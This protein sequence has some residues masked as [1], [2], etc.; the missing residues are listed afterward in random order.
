MDIKPKIGPKHFPSLFDYD[1]DSNNRVAH[2]YLK[3]ISKENLRRFDPWGLAYVEFIQAQGQEVKKIVYGLKNPHSNLKHFEAFKRRTSFL[4]INNS[5][6]SFEIKMEN[7][8]YKLYQLEGLKRRPANEIIRDSINIRS[9]DNVSGRLEKDFQVFLFGSQQISNAKI[10]ERLGLLGFDFYNLKTSYLSIREFPTGVFD[11]KVSRNTM[12]LPADFIDF[13]SFNKYGQLSLIEIKVNDSKL[14]SISQ[15]LDYILY[16]YS[17]RSKLNQLIKI[18][19]QKN[20]YPPKFITKKYI[21]YL[22][23]N[24]FHLQFDKI[25]KYYSTQ[26]SYFDFELKQI[27]LGATENI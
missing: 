11:Q 7:N 19:L 18:T 8:P 26:N 6:L 2:L 16:F 4:H 13:V 25:K 23:N 3:R 15:I 1:Y 14:E 17:Y 22:I 27:K 21:G 12:I 9:A 10:R 5:N 24:Y 20:N